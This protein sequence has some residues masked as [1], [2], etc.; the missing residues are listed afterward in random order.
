M[1]TNDDNKF[2]VQAENLQI[3]RGK[4][5]VSSRWFCSR[6]G[7]PSNIFYDCVE[8]LSNTPYLENNI[9]W[10]SDDDFGSLMHTRVGSYFTAA[11]ADAV[12]SLL[13]GGKEHGWL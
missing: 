1:D 13:R 11:Q 4:L 9:P 5:V 6:F 3:R 10:I 7:I 12:A 8:Q 2:D